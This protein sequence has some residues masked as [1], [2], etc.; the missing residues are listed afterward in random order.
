M[1]DRHISSTSSSM[2]LFV[3]ALLVAAAGPAKDSPNCWC[4]GFLELD[5]EIHRVWR[6]E[7]AYLDSCDATDDCKAVCAAEFDASTGGGDLNFVMNNGYSVGQYICLTIAEEHE[8]F[9]VHHA[10]VYGYANMCNGPW[11]YDGASTTGDLLCCRDGIYQ[12]C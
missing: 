4:G 5:D 12:A 11:V 8:L 7:A 9:H 2:K 6:L 10:R 1:G 3:V